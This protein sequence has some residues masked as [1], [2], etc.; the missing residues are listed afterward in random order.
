MDIVL[1]YLWSRSRGSVPNG[2]CTA[3]TKTTTTITTTTITTITTTKALNSVRIVL[4]KPIV[5]EP[6]KRSKR[7]L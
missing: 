6:G 2:A 4:N 7:G 1:A 5:R 3:S